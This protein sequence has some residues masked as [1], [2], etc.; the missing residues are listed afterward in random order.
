MEEFD[1]FNVIILGII[2]DPK[3]KKV[4]IGRRENDPNIPE[5]TW[6]FPGGRAVIGED[7]DK[8][9]KK[10]VQ[11]KTGYIVK[12]LGTFFSDTYVKKNN[13][14]RIYFLTEVFEGEEKPNDG[15]VELKWVHPK[16]LKNHFTTSY[17]KKLHEYLMNLV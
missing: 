7:V 10:N 6:C 9:L 1:K 17:H 2:F 11:S 12:N 3:N 15:F 16:E 14:I 5:L 4:L 13:L 8:T